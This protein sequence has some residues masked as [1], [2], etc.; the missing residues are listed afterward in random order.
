[1]M[2]STYT[3]TSKMPLPTSAPEPRI[4][5]TAEAVRFKMDT[6]MEPS[7]QWLIDVKKLLS[8]PHL[9]S[10]YWYDNACICITHRNANAV[11]RFEKKWAAR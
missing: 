8:S 10:A 3:I 2:H 1:M 7:I 6:D 5:A 11:E 4:I 9:V